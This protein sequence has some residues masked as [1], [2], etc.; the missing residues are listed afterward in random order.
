MILPALISVLALA[1]APSTT[2]V[3]CNPGLASTLEAGVTFSNVIT[4]EPDGKI[5]MGTLNIIQLGPL[6]CG[7]LLYASENPSERL[8]TQRL[9][10]GVDFD[11]LLGV[12]LQVALHEANHVALNSSDECLVEKTT[13][14]SIDRLIEQYGGSKTA[15][16]DAAAS[17]AELPAQYHG[18]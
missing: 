6:A 11:N 13:R 8:A 2:T 17:D 1:G 15:E 16:A 5:I 10:P 7:G 18:C 4:V 3:Q 12:G 9:N 14:Q